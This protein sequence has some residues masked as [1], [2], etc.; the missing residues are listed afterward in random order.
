M[1]KSILCLIMLDGYPLLLTKYE[2]FGQEIWA[3]LQIREE[4]ESLVRETEDRTEET[5]HQVDT[6]WSR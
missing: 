2:W 4:L 5:L 3:T 6:A 1:C